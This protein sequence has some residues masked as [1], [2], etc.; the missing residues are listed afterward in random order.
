MYGRADDGVQFRVPDPDARAETVMYISTEPCPMCADG[1]AKA[2]Y[3]QI[4]YSVSSDEITAFTGTEPSARSAAI[5][6]DVTDIVG[7]VLNEEGQKI[8]EEFDC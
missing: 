1:M 2:G 4:V 8:H 7:P 3:G 6:E 5:L